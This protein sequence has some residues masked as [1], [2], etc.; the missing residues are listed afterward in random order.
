MRYGI[1]LVG[2]RVAPRCIF[3]E[4]V[5]I[6]AL[7]GN[8]ARV[9]GRVSLDSHGLL[10]LADVLSQG[11][12]DALICGG[13]SR[14]EHEFLS[15]RRLEVIDNIAGSVHELVE[16]L[17]SGLLR[18]GLCLSGANSV[19]SQDLSAPELSEIVVSVASTGYG[20][21]RAAA[22][23]CLACDDQKCLQGG[24]CPLPAPGLVSKP[25]G[26]DHARLFEAMADIASEEGQTLCRLSELIYFCLEMH[27]ERV[28]VAYCVDLQEPAEILVRLLR[29]FLKVHPVCC[30][31]GAPGTGALNLPEA[32]A[33]KRGRSACCNP[34]GQ[35]DAMNAMRTE[36]NILVGLCMG[37]DC[38]F[39]RFSNAP[40]TTLFVKDRSLANNPIAAL[41]SGRYLKE[42]IQAVPRRVAQVPQ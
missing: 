40:V 25:A 8:R 17:Q 28:G 1:V 5:L 36:L 41:Y 34:L 38:L 2:D 33:P 30:R 39:A 32:G 29:R 7:R 27:Y 22:I 21:S 12:I 14:E 42:A 26:R 13:I 23:D 19:P 16:A 6:V 18:S 37:A 24:A 20:D 3:A 15:A 31:I 9:E 10:H 35:A 11:H 4:S